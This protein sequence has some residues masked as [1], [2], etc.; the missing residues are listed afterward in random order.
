MNILKNIILVIA[1]SFLSL[2]IAKAQGPAPDFKIVD[3][4]RGNETV[5]ENKFVKISTFKKIEMLAVYDFDGD[6]IKDT[7]YYKLGTRNNTVTATIQ[8]YDIKKDN[9]VV[10]YT[11]D[12]KGLAGTDG[13]YFFTTNLDDNPTPEFVLYT[14]KKGFKSATI[15]RYKADKKAFIVNEYPLNDKNYYPHK[16]VVNKRLFHNAKGNDA[17]TFDELPLKE[18]DK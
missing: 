14:V 16:L 3:I 11:T 13:L 2:G 18:D 12:I 9:W 10:L 8:W 15:M 17:Q 7:I 4:I 5:H 1:L 6:G